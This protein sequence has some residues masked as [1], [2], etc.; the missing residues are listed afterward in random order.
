MFGPGQILNKNPLI[1]IIKANE[2]F[3]IQVLK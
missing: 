1:F 2:I 3:A